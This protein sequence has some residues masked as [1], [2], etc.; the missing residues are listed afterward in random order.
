MQQMQ[1]EDAQGG[2]LYHVHSRALNTNMFESCGRAYGQLIT[3]PD[4]PI[5]SI[6]PHFCEP[7]GH[8]AAAEALAEALEHCLAFAGTIWMQCAARYSG[9]PYKLLGL[10]DPVTTL[11][12]RDELAAELVAAPGC[13]VDEDFT[14]KARVSF[15]LFF[16][17]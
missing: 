16:K 2:V 15:G 14:K 4:S 9:W 17:R 3:S 12:A 13:C 6:L 1:M 7:P 8:A 5:L 10:V 11:D